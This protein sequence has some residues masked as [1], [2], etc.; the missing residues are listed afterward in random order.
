MNLN[1]SGDPQKDSYMIMVQ[2]K[3]IETICETLKKRSVDSEDIRLLLNLELA[4]LDI[5]DCA[6]SIYDLSGENS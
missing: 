3:R 2:S 4:L 6:K 1:V 5:K